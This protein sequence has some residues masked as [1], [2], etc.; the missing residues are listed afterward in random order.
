MVMKKFIN[1]PADLTQELLEGYAMAYPNKISVESEKLVVRTNPKDKV[2]VITLGGAGHE[3]ALSGFVGKGMLDINVV[4]HIFAAPGPPKVFEALKT[5]A[6]D[7]GT[8][9]VV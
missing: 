9:F 2:A 6:R 1:D 8:L 5:A 4:G 7:A 3:P